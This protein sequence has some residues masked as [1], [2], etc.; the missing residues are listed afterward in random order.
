[1]L[2]GKCR[3]F[4]AELS[5]S[6]KSVFLLPHIN[7]SIYKWIFAKRYVHYIVKIWIANEQISSIFDKVICPPYD[8]SGVLSFHVF[9]F[10]MFVCLIDY[11]IV[12]SFTYFIMRQTAFS[13][14]FFFFFFFCF[15]FS[16]RNTYF[17][18]Q[19]RLK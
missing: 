7:L 1:M 3:Q 13:S 17:Q 18:T 16:T 8:S 2:T 15:F 14:K 6:H 9:N 12:V 19:M 10:I 5:A 11:I 4:L